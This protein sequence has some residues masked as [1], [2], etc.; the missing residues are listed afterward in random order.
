MVKKEKKE[1]DCGS[2][3]KWLKLSFLCPAILVEAASDLLGV[4]SGSGVE[5]GLES[6]AGSWLS[7]YFHV[8]A[9]AEAVC[10]EQMEHLVGAVQTALAELFA[11]FN[12]PLPEFR[13]E[14]LADEDWATSWQQHFKTFTIAP[15]LVIKPSWE[16]Y[17]PL[18]G[19]QVLEMDPGMA[20]GT[21]QHASTRGAL[22]L[23]ERS[24]RQHRPGQVLDVGTGTGILAMGAA[25]WGAGE[26]LAIDNDPEAVRV[27]WENVAHNRLSD[28]ITVAATPL[29]EVRGHYDLLLANI[30]H[31]VLVE[32]QPLLGRLAA[33]SAQ[34]VLAGILAGSQEENII[35][36]YGQAGFHLLERTYEEEW[37]ALRFARY[38]VR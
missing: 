12:Q 3:G 35:R 13:R 5:Q 9:G 31:D 25:L 18:P 27:A 4:H 1:Q 17:A 23:V 37:V 7:G 11:L 28:R 22:Y 36:C 32:M 19:E 21:G 15:G 2:A 10:Q 29:A 30:V 8:E 33:L 26:V 6:E 20:F 24:F 14:L 34:L 38:F 16:E